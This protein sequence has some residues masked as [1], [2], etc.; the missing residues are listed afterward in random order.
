MHCGPE[1]EDPI[2]KDCAAFEKCYERLREC[3]IHYL[4]RTDDFNGG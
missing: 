1:I 4:E 2:G 3:I